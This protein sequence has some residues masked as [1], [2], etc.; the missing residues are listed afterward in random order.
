MIMSN[1]LVKIS[2]KKLILINVF[3]ILIHLYG[4]IIIGK[5]SE[6]SALILFIYQTVYPLF[7]IIIILFYLKKEKPYSLNE[8]IKILMAILNLLFFIFA[9][10]WWIA[11]LA[12][13][14]LDY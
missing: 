7:F 8:T 13:K 12:F 11:A 4:F 5:L 3:M 1:L 9:I 2:L 14:D 10:Y 6:L